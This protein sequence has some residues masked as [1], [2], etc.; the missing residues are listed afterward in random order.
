MKIGEML[1][2]KREK[3]GLSFEQITKRTRIPLKYIK[4]LESGEYGEF[5]AEVYVIGFLR[6]YS[7]FLGLDS[8]EIVAVY[9]ASKGRNTDDD[10]AAAPSRKMKKTAVAGILVW[11]L[12]AV[13]IGTVSVKVLEHR[14]SILKYPCENGKSS[15]TSAAEGSPGAGLKLEIAAK[16]DSWIRVVADGAQIFEG[17]LSGGRNETWTAKNKFY[18]ISGYVPGI[19]VRLNGV[20]VDMGRNAKQDVG[21]ITLYA[22]KD[23]R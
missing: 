21:E 15:V 1:K 11:T 20:P 7:A 6:N 12:M 19:E 18:V 3:T 2:T 22:D 17:I 16:Q 10:V 5:P 14:Y 23:G 9:N 4:A 13:A 8:D